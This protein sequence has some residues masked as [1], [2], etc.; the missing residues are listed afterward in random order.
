MGTLASRLF[1]L[2]IGLGFF[3]S[4]IPAHGQ[5]DLSVTKTVNTPYPAPGNPVEFTVEITNNGP[6]A[7]S[8][9]E[10]TDQ[11]PP[12]LT[13]PE[14]TAPFTSQGFYDPQNG[15]WEIGAL[16]SLETAVLTIPALPEQATSSTCHVNLATATSSTSDDPDWSND[17]SLAAIYSGAAT[18][19][20]RLTLVSRL[21]QAPRTGSPTVILDVE[22]WNDG[23]DTAKGVGLRLSGV[24]NVSNLDRDTFFGDLSAAHVL[25]GTASWTYDCGIGAF[26][27]AYTITVYAETTT[28][29]DSILTASDTISVP[30][31]G[32][33]SI[34][35]ALVQ[36]ISSGGCFIAT[37]AYGS[38]LDAHV[39]ELRKFRDN[40][41]MTS[42]AGRKLV[43]LYY[44]FS[45][46]I[47]DVIAR[48]ESL[49]FLTRLLLS[50]L[51]YAFSFPFVFSSTLF[52]LILAT[53]TVLVRG[54]REAL[55]HVKLQGYRLRK[56]RRAG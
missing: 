7:A 2:G 56:G 24:D 31:T 34:P 13:I 15:I 18:D 41:L 1:V 46:P 4:T 55:G 27:E 16:Q 48:H 38:D 43:G 14:G 29:S 35:D 51:I 42:A 22:I 49:R 6:D 5:A 36:G 37:A 17:W 11:L 23:P 52:A 3:A 47:A 10:L 8:G 26:T 28:A 45:P 9:I 19:C 50:P 54:R 44:R 21:E 12:S 53:T 32:A 33:C 20:A 39:K 40:H 30:I 25:N